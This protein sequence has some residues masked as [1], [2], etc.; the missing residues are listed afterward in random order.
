MVRSSEPVDVVRSWA[1]CLRL[2]DRD[3]ALALYASDAR[4]HAGTSVLAGRSRL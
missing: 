4:V 1:D 3:G 2:G